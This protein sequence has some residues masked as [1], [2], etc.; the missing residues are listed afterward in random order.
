MISIKFHI[1]LPQPA[2][3]TASSS[4]DT[5]E[6][7]EQE[8]EIFVG[9]VREAAKLIYG[10]T[11]SSSRMRAG[12]IERNRSAVNKWLMQDYFGENQIYTTEMFRRLFRMSMKLFEQIVEDLAEEYPYFRLRNELIAKQ[13][14]FSNTKVYFRYSEIGLPSHLTSSWG[15]EIKH[16]KIHNL[17]TGIMNIYGKQYLRKPTFVDVQKLYAAYEA[18]QGFP[19]I[20][21]SL[22]YTHWMVAN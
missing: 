18:E 22:D 5:V 16:H 20:L 17:C 10:S 11:A 9:L 8:R 4:T 12:N 2:S 7:L 21:G 6:E 3:S 14:F 19:G 15:W 1:D 13:G